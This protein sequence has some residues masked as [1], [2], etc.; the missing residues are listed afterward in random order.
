VGGATSA[1]VGPTAGDTVLT[2]HDRPADR[3]ML[4]ARTG[5]RTMGRERTMSAATGNL[6]TV[7]SA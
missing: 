3:M 2:R 6:A 1:R 7:A 5:A 4:L